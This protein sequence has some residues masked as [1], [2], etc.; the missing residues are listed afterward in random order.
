MRLTNGRRDPL[1]PR[2]SRAVRARR[3]GGSE[4]ACW[5]VAARPVPTPSALWAGI[6]GTRT[7]P[8]R[9]NPRSRSRAYPHATRCPV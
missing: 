8:R 9:R 7:N 2:A 5:F 6:T 1:D 4:P 3:A